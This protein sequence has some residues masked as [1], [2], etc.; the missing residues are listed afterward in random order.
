[1]PAETYTDKNYTDKLTYPERVA[2]VAGRDGE[3]I[4]RVL[5]VRLS[6]PEVL[7]VSRRA[8]ETFRQRGFTEREKKEAMAEFKGR[9]EALER[10]IHE[11]QGIVSSQI[12]YRSIQC[13]KITHRDLG[14]VVITRLDNG[15]IVET[16]PMTAKERQTEM[17]L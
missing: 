11:L 15:S 1:M 5:P 7:D 4:E 14:E 9:V 17:E 2:E 8:A 16:R 6:D 10:E 12:E 13:E 3:I